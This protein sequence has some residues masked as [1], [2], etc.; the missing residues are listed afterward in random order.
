MSKFSK[1]DAQVLLDNS[2]FKYIIETLEKEFCE[3]FISSSF[4]SDNIR[5]TANIKINT[6]RDLRSRIEALATN[7]VDS[8]KKHIA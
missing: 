6:L 2:L 4:S 7:S 8:Q 3:D 1:A 5:L